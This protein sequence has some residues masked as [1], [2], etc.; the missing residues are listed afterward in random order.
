[1]NT[2]ESPW[3]V[4]N[5]C[6]KSIAFEQTYYVCSVSTCNRKRTGFFF[7]SIPCWD[8]HLPIMRH[9]EAWA[10][11]IRAPTQAAWERAQKAEQE[12]T[13]VRARPAPSAPLRGSAPG[14][15]QADTLPK[16]VLVVVSKLKQ[17]IKQ[18]ANM[19]TSD[20]V[21]GV[22][23]DHLRDL[24]N[25]AIDNAAQDGRRTVMDRDFLHDG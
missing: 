7:C 19:N 9:R 16:D 24:C 8:T 5:I 25:Q 18:H 20:N 21:T 11:E 14:D 12:K 2:E 22:L 15:D 4:C 23:S 1:M 6:K 17:Y 3:R 13:A 10:E